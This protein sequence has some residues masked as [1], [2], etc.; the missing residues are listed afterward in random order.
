MRILMLSVLLACVATE[1]LA[2]D[3]PQFMGPQRDGVWREEGILEKFP[4][5]GPKIR[6]RVPVGIGYAGPA[7]ANG[8]VIV[9]DRQLAEGSTNPQ[10]QFARDV[11]KGTERIVCLNEADGKQI[12]V[13]EYDAAYDISYP[14]GPRTTPVIADGKVYALGAVG[15]LRCLNLADGALVWSKNFK[16]D[17]GVETPTWGFSSSPLIDGN[18]LICLARGVNTTVIAY[19]KD[20]GKEIWKALTAPEPGYS[21]PVIYD[22]AGKRT[23]VIWHP[24]SINGLEPDTGAVLWSY[25]FAVR[26]G[27]TAPMARAIPQ[28][29][30]G[31]LLFVTSFYNGPVMLKFAKGAVKPTLLWKGTAGNEKNTDILHSIMPTPFIDGDHIYGVCSYGQLRCIEIATGKRVWESFIATGGPYPKAEG[32]R[33]ANAFLIK[34]GDRFFL[35]NEKGDLI[36]AKL[37]PQG[38]TE[39]SRAHILEPTGRAIARPVVWSH[40]AFV[41][42]AMIARNDREV[43][44][45][46][47]A[48]E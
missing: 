30:G 10:N 45:V 21:P 28:A 32:E 43:V 35:P 11:V 34:N 16:K 22:I 17:I 31:T 40:P 8:K 44:C 9:C 26:M 38:Y 25:P 39:I 47:L 41:N 3:W 20:T 33:W 2:A 27:L 18:K 1:I 48:K 36:I 6:W 37:S 29:D 24:E 4:A 13:H 23:L 42:K 46:E 19:E 7:V 15:D 14:A 12:W 5:G